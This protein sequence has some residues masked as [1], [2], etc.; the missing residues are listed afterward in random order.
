MFYILASMAI[1]YAFSTL[2]SIYKKGIFVEQK[3][4]LM[5]KTD[6]EFIALLVCVDKYPN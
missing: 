3:L 1:F 4:L 6:K 5:Q 2:L